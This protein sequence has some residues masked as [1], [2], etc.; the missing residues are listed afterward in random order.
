MAKLV[1]KLKKSG[2][3]EDAVLYQTKNKLLAAAPFRKKKTPYSIIHWLGGNSIITHPVVSDFD[4]IA[5]GAAGISKAAVDALAAYLGISRKVLAEDIFDLS[6][7][8][9][10]RKSPADKLDKRTSS[11]A[12]EIAGVLQHAFEVFEDE[13]KVKRWVN[14]GN[15][16]L[17]GAKPL[18]LFAT[19]TGL[20]IVNDIL[21]RV[22]EGVY[23]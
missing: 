10:E 20:T 4:L 18:D 21:G 13:E 6:V 15:R 11:H 9:F 14:T 22:E 16:A 3:N 17:N 23:S 19:L 2:I 1:T 8:T 12:L 5:I 7:K